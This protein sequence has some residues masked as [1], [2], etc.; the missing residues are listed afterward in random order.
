M[1]E[2]V[3][4]WLGGLLRNVRA[5]HGGLAIVQEELQLPSSA[6]DLS[7]PAF[8]NG[9]RLPTRFTADGEGVSPPLVWGPVPEGTRSLALLVE[10]PDAPAP[11]PLVH[12]IVWN[13]PAGERGLR[14]GA[15][16]RDGSG[17][18]D[19]RD[20]GRSSF[21]VEGWLPPDPPTG[22]GS[23]DYVFQLF[24]LGE[25]SDPGDSPARSD[26][27]D[28]M[29]GNVLAAGVLVG[30]YSRGEEAPVGGAAAYRGATA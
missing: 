28:A 4:H 9:A 5:G 21:F 20:V 24:A 8:G 11:W 6:I 23:H 10:D 13:L 14:E 15:I 1:L 30:T 2:H 16:V 18:P 7:S 22:H 19:G 3:P 29:A 26:L 12:A 27:M 17:G 25:T